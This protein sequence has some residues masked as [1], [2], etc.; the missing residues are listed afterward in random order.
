[1]NILM[2]FIL[3][4]FWACTHIATGAGNVPDARYQIA[5]THTSQQESCLLWPSQCP[6]V[7]A[8][9][10]RPAHQATCILCIFPTS[11]LMYV[12]CMHHV[13][14]HVMCSSMQSTDVTSASSCIEGLMW[15]LDKLL[16]NDLH[17][18]PCYKCD[19][20]Y[21]TCGAG[22]F[23]IEASQTTELSQ[24]QLTGMECHCMIC[25]HVLCLTSIHV[26]I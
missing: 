11:I 13:T 22:F 17:T 25:T 2:L 4:P 12:S 26:I 9:G 14:Q 23:L 10:T 19:H 18:Q 8:V 1:M 7:N 15:C 3:D 21:G 24:C 16:R 5:L 20:V 6:Q